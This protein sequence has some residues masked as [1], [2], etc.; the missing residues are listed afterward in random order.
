MLSQRLIHNENQF[1]ILKKKFFHL[2]SSVKLDFDSHN[3]PTLLIITTQRTGSTVLCND[4]EQSCN[5]NYI[6]T[7]TFVPA[8]TYLFNNYPDHDI[9]NLEKILNK[10]FKIPLKGPVYIH[11]LMI[12]YVGWIGFLCAPKEFVRNASYFDLSVWTIKTIIEKSK[13]NLPLLFLYRA[14]KL[15]QASSRL[16]NSMGFSTHLSTDQ[17]KVNFSEKVKKRIKNL[18]HPEG[19]ILDQ[20]SIIIK[21]NDILEKIYKVTSNQYKTIKLNYEN[22]ICD[23]SYNYLNKC[24]PNNLCDIS[25]ISRKLKKT[26]NNNSQN[27]IN[28]TKKSLGLI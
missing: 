16:I 28:S 24:I 14:N 8:L 18:P 6:P 4:L 3:L 27:L 1:S 11:K 25:R 21:Q 13:N 23:E 10:A 5:L 26:S 15:S 9:N 7:E 2:S 12:D 17:E 22:D 19:M 20:A